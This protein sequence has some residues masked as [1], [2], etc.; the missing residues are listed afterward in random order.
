ML[1]H[2]GD[3]DLLLL[4]PAARRK[5]WNPRANFRALSLF[6][7]WGRSP[8]RAGFDNQS[9]GSDSDQRCDTDRLAAIRSCNRRCYCAGHDGKVTLS[10]VPHAV[11]RQGRS[12]QGRHQRP[13][14]DRRP[15]GIFDRIVRL[16]PQR[17][18]HDHGRRQTAE[19]SSRP[20]SH[21]CRKQRSGAVGNRRVW[22]RCFRHR[23]SVTKM[24]PPSGTAAP[25]CGK[26]PP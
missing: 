15:E 18:G 21:R 13:G 22:P 5:S 8:T 7:L 11:P 17:K 16:V 3:A 19:R 6:R 20:Q 25:E 14:I 24:F 23:S 1:L 26:L 2:L 9:P 12:N 10:T 4:P